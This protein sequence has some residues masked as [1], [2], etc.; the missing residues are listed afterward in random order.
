LALVYSAPFTVTENAS[1]AYDMLPAGVASNNLWMSTNGFMSST[2]NDTRVETLGGLEQPWLVVDN[3]TWT[4][5]PVPADSQTNLYFTT[6]GSEADSMD[7]ITGYDGYVTIADDPALELGDNG[8]IE[9]SGWIDTTVIGEEL[10]GKSDAFRTYILGTTNITSEISWGTGTETLAP[11][12]AGDETNIPN[13]VGAAT[14]WQAELTDDADVSYVWTAGAGYTRDLYTTNNTIVNRGTISSVTIHVVAKET[15]GDSWVRTAIKTGGVAF[16]G[17]ETALTGA[18]ETYSTGYSTNPQTTNT[19]TWAEVDAMQIGVSVRTDGGGSNSRSTQVSAT[20]AYDPTLSVN[21]TGV[22]SGN[23]TVTTT[24]DSTDLKIFVDGAE[25]DSIA[26]VGATVIDNAN[27]WVLGA[28]NTLPYT[29]YYRHTVGNSTATGFSDPG[30]TWAGE[31]FAYDGRIAT[32]AVQNTPASSWGDYLTLTYASIATTRLDFYM[33]SA[34][35]FCDGMEIDTSVGGVTWTNIY[36]AD[37]PEITMTA[38]DFAIQQDVTQ[39]RVRFHNSDVVPQ[40]ISLAELEPHPFIAWYQPNAI[41]LT[42][43]LPDRAGG[44]HPGVITWGANP[45]GVA[46]TL[47]SL[48][49][50]SQPTIGVEPDDPTRD[51]LPEAQVSDWFAP[52][53]VTGALLTNPLRPFVVI[54]SDTTTLSEQQAWVWLGIAVVLSVL[55]LTAKSVRGHYLI[56][57]VATAVVIGA[58]V[59]QTVFPVWALVFAVIAVVGGIVAERSPSL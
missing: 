56:T 32:L 57:G 51:I 40:L 58:M 16:D 4:A 19:W 46:V 17:A 18:Y 2:A 49:A 8:N 25:E 36:S 7:I 33:G 9:Q 29:D 15:I 53:A 28:N 24:L 27:D 54:L 14:H 3:M 42:N 26:L 31:A 30:A 34:G 39:I 22:A 52:P 50:E 59:Q 20:V 6:G 35:A 41:I 37:P 12:G 13:L 10:V 45:V 38:V 1:V 43:V 23:H 47:A 55:V 48:V 5:I 21:A 11:D 44:D